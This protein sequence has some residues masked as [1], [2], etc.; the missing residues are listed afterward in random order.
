MEHNAFQKPPYFDWSLDR[1]KVA[2]I[3]L[4]FVAVLFGTLFDPNWNGG[5]PT[6]NSPEMSDVAAANEASAVD[7]AT[8]A[9]SASTAEPDAVDSADGAE[10][11]G[12]VLPLTLAS[13][14]PNAVVSS[15]GIASLSGTARAASRIEIRD[16]VMAQ[17]DLTQVPVPASEEELIGVATVDQRGFWTVP[18]ETVLQPGHHIMTVRELD[19]GGDL[20]SVSSPVVVLVLESGEE[21]PLSLATPV[22]RFPAPAATLR[23]GQAVFLGSGLPGMRVRLALDGRPVAEGVVNSR[24]E[25]RLT[26]EVDL[27]PGVY[28]AGVSALDP[29]GEVVA[30]SPP[31]AFT[32]VEPVEGLA[33]TEPITTPVV[34]SVGTIPPL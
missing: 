5:I 11:T 7:E 23:S 33:P 20:L 3:A 25:W 14:G 12:A 31:V 6:R 2:V 10:E 29:Q 30:Q 13:L 28:V 4:L 32:V 8:G 21:G 26:P 18:L 19:E 24:E 22:I 17:A 34:S 1:W 15:A 9:E 16:Q 27:E